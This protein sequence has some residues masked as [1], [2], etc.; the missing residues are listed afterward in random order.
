MQLKSGGYIVINQTEA[1]VAIDVN[2]GRAT[3]ERNIEETALKT[4]LEAAEETA[5]Q[6]RLRDLAGLIVIDFIDMEE[7]RNNAA[8]ERRLKDAMR[9]DRARIQIGRISPFGLLELSRQRL[10]PSLIEATMMH[11]A[12]CGGSGWVR[13]T[14]LTVLH[15]LRG[16][17]EEGIRQRSAELRLTVPTSV[18]L[19][20]LNQKRAVLA[21]LERRYRFA[22]LV[23]TDDSLVP[24]AFRLE[25]VKAAEA[26]EHVPPPVSHETVSGAV[27]AGVSEAAEAPAS[28]VGEPEPERTEASE[29]RRPGE[30]GEERRPGEPGEERRPGE[31]G[32]GRRRRRR[33]RRRRGADEEGAETATGGTRPSEA[34]ISSRAAEE[35]E[36]GGASQRLA[37]PPAFLGE[38][39]TLPSSE[40][41][42][43]GATAPL[44][45]EEAG[46]APS[47]AEEERDGHRR[48]A[49]GRRGGRR[50]RRG[51]RPRD[52]FEPASAP[53]AASARHPREAA[54]SWPNPPPQGE[55]PRGEREPELVAAG[56]ELATTGEPGVPSW[57]EQPQAAEREGEE[58]ERR[59]RERPRR[60][61]EED[62][63]KPAPSEPPAGEPAEP[64]ASAPPA[65]EPEAPV[66]PVIQVGTKREEVLPK[67]RGWWQR[68]TE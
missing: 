38:A 55:P 24:P 26:G 34:A 5:R 39:A 60:D 52:D 15:V 12:Q 44:P 65:P 61:R 59:Q 43:S 1:L 28:E 45:Y 35:G 36:A 47:A 41:E 13:S 42:E 20:I 68:F 8:V 19:Y 16:L 32:E 54:A 30:P 4:N 50:R 14:E 2:S 17:E 6:L 31:P 11:C 63:A 53:S 37:E 18:A 10:R 57:L 62:E 33:R 27:G 66:I 9:A 3:R 40:R 29:E 7:P 21:D 23:D 25:R 22:V 64:A 46:Q 49:R 48:R 56:D 51:E 58:G 67:K